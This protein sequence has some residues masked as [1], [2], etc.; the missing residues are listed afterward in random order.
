MAATIIIPT[1]GRPD[2]LEETL[3]SVGPQAARAGAGLLVVDDG[4]DPRTGEVS[5][6]HGV[7]ML[8]TGG[9]RGANGA[10]NAGV[11]ASDG[12]LLVFIDD[13]IRAPEG[14]LRALLDGSAASPEIDVFGGPIIAAIEGG[15][16]SCGR[17]G[18]PIT[19]LDLGP[20][21]RDAELVWSANMAVR[22]R[23]L[24]RVGPF[25]ETIH[26]R[27]EEEDW[28]RRY[29]ALGGRIRYLAAAG[30]EHRR[31]GADARLKALARSGYALGRTARRYDLR[32]GTAPTLR[33][34][35]RV[36]AG[37]ALHVLRR[38][39]PNM[40]AVGAQAAG[41]VREALAESGAVSDVGADDFLSGES[42][43][44]SGIRATARALAGDL[45]CDGLALARADPW[46]L[47]A[48]ARTLPP[49]RVLVLAVERTDRENLLADARR[50]LQRSRHEVT[51]ATKGVDGAG[52]F[53]NLNA[54]LR[55]HPPQGYDWLLVIDDDVALPR[56]FLDV[57]LFLAERFDLALAQP[58]HRR[59]SHA[60]WRVT[61]RRPGRVAHETRFVEI[62]PITA[63][64]AC[65]FD[66]LLPFPE[67]R[68]GWGLE[69]HWSALARA[70]GWREGVIDAVPIAH[71]LRRVASAYP[72]EEARAEARQFLAGRAYTPATEAQRVLAEHRGWRR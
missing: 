57:F 65:T 21:D 12:D 3:A 71:A 47:R 63:F 33:D 2:Y 49:R 38:R 8:S 46:R 36:L 15:P 58:A 27:G 11:A 68:F 16:R 13:D 59:R 70:R 42:G 55:E 26:G 44:V 66:A 19:T 39:C 48:A 14:W 6:H 62:G 22:R 67:L 18:A 45:W 51:L 4:T 69:L 20:A 5:A 64:R 35:L 56:D 43:E 41:R 34:E 32:K 60:A 53:E 23:A 54:L 17:E 72:A 9:G 30:V 50:E 61:R 29:L 31:T 25:D 7:A 10:R 28:E 40:I 52:K 24:E 1:R 37:C